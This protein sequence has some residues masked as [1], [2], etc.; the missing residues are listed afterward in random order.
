MS[1]F[2]E[3]GFK[4]NTKPL[5]DINDELTKLPPNAKKAEDA[6]E[7]LNREVNK[8]GPVAKAAAG[9]L[10]SLT[11]M[12]MKFAT[13]AATYFSVQAI[14]GY[15]DAWS[16]MQSVVGAAIKDM[17]AAP[18][19]MERILDI[20]NASYSPLEQTATIYA[21]NVGVLNA[22]GLGAKEAADYT[23]SLNHMLVITATR[24]ERAASVQN[25]L[26]KAMAV[27]KL[28]AEGLETIL[29]HGGRVAEALAEEL[30]T[31]V[32]GLR[33]MASQG[34]ITSQVIAQALLKSLEDV[35]VEAGDMTAT[36]T[37][38][39]VIMN[40]NITAAIGQFDKMHG[41]SATVAEGIIFLAENLDL[42]A[43]GVTGVAVAINVALLPAFLKMTAAAAVFTTTLLANPLTW[44]AALAG[45]AATALFQVINAQNLAAQAAQTHAENL[46]TNA[47]AI[48]V[49]KTSSQGFRDSLRGQI[50]M[51]LAAAKAALNEAGAQYQA[52]KASAIRAD[53]FG[54]MM[55]SMAKAMGMPGRE[56]DYG[57]EIMRRALANINEAYGRVVELQG[58]LGKLGEVEENYKPIEH[59]LN[60][61]DAL[62]DKSKTAATKVAE[63][64]ET[65]KEAW[66]AA[67][68]EWDFYGSTFSGFFRDMRSDLMNGVGFWDSF[69][70]AA[71]KALDNIASRMLDMATS[72]IFNMIFGAFMPNSAGAGW[73][74]FG[75]FAG[76]PGM[77][78]LPGFSNGG[79][80]GNGATGAAAGIVHGKEF[81]VNA[82]ATQAVGVSALQAINDNHV[83]PANDNGGG[84]FVYQDNRSYD[85]SGTGLSAEEIREILAEDREELINNMP[86]IISAYQNDPRKRKVG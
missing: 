42:V 39:F 4:T 76:K 77:F 29:A 21:R 59:T 20:A 33:G 32:N 31:T 19:M 66:K 62:G 25:A 49:A 72:Q 6:T 38:A 23:E 11:S 16:D 84:G 37:D 52:A 17:E 68:A 3:L 5:V 53:A 47:N 15:V 28:Q 83:L 70:N 2:A 57:D 56:V 40:N 61:I 41:V 22:L 79:Y 86:E 36:I 26:S 45:A 78:G 58:Q 82:A 74:V 18:A 44:Y 60:S 10:N 63:A 51:Q 54:A 43:A 71:S 81:V 67:K 13:A 85:F 46:V 35:R 55:N 30:G 64:T 7:R 48:E 12:A 8:T 9:G 65:M 1:D 73:G 24:G 27:G 14:T 34:K 75:G 50:E 80:T 69:K